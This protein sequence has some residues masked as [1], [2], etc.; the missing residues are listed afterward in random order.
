MSARRPAVDGSAVSGLAAVRVPAPGMAAAAVTRAATRPLF[1][2]ARV[3]V[4][5]TRVSAGSG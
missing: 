4:G 3:D 5:L 2:V 1:R